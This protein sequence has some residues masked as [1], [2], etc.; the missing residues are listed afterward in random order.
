M[1]FGSA[2]KTKRFEL[3]ISQEELA[4]RAGLHRTYVSDVE[5]GTRNPSLES[6]EKLAQALEMSVSNLF[7]FATKEP[8]Q[9]ERMVEILLVDDSGNDAEIA[10]RAF[11][12]ACIANPLRVLEDGA[13]ALDY[14]FARGA[15]AWREG[16]PAPGLVLLDLNLPGVHGREV[17]RQIKSNPRT[18]EIPVVVLTMSH[19]EKDIAAC[20]RLGARAYLVKPVHFQNF[21]QVTPLFGME[22]ALMKPSIQ[23]GD[24]G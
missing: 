3:G 20:R 7:E 16:E 23:R 21:S 13:Q 11:R 6:I 15:Y 14:L 24:G 2:V 1:I 19:H 18:K 8:A 5:R 17:L 10:I 9:E 12:K 4:D 22:W